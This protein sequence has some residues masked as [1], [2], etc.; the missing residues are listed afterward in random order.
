MIGRTLPAEIP[1]TA[2]ERRNGEGADQARE[3]IS[4]RPARDR[5]DA[6]RGG[7]HPFRL[8]RGGEARRLRPRRRPR[9]LR[10]LRGVMSVHTSLTYARHSSLEPGLPTAD[11]PSG[12]LPV[13]QPERVLLLVV[14]QD[15]VGAGVVLRVRRHALLPLVQVVWKLR[16]LSRW[17]A[18]ELRAAAIRVDAPACVTGFVVRAAVRASACRMA[19]VRSPERQAAAPPPPTAFPWLKRST[20]DNPSVTRWRVTLGRQALRRRF[21]EVN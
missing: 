8:G 12:D 16:R 2:D 17:S 9:P 13:R 4:S 20:V 14:D 1:A 18:S 10:R 3:M 7:T 6:C 21:F 11:Q 15:D 5:R 19:A